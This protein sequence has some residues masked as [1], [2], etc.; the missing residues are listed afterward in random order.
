MIKPVT[1]RAV[2]RC[3]CQ[4]WWQQQRHMMDR[5]WLH[6]LITKWAKNPRA[7]RALRQA[8]DPGLLKLTLFIW[9]CFTLSANSQNTFFL[10]PPTKILDPLLYTTLLLRTNLSCES[11]NKPWISILCGIPL[12]VFT[13]F[14]FQSDKFKPTRLHISTKL[15]NVSFL[16]QGVSIVMSD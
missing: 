12:N 7:S 1:G 16:A 4:W 11:M 14:E 10:P 13:L 5:A 9:L 6:R 2:H 3:R 8:L 15:I